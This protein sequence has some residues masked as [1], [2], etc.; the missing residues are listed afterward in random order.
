ML[1]YCSQTFL[2]T[3]YNLT[4]F[5]TKT[6]TYSLLVFLLKIVPKYSKQSIFNEYRSVCKRIKVTHLPHICL[7]V[8]EVSFFTYFKSSIGARGRTVIRAHAQLS[9]ARQGETESARLRRAYN[10]NKPAPTPMAARKSFLRR[11]TAV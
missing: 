3:L 11:V 5:F 6:P 8:L 1:D 9:W 2:C 10:A 7:L 4:C